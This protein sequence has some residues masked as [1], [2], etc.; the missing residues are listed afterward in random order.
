MKCF[1]HAVFLAHVTILAHSVVAY[2]A[3]KIAFSY[4]H[5]PESLSEL[6]LFSINLLRIVIV[7]IVLIGDKF[8]Q[9]ICHQP[10]FNHQIIKKEEKLQ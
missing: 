10:N 1:L 6:N 8:K 2:N 9:T 4:Q 5:L 3:D 7:F